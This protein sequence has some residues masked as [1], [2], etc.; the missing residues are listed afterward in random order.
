MRTNTQISLFDPTDPDE[1]HDV[2]V[3][4]KFTVER[5]PETRRICVEVERIVVCETREDIDVDERQDDVRDACE[6]A[7]ADAQ[8]EDP[9]DVRDRL[10]DARRDAA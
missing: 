9:D 3:E 1:F 7:W 6:Q 4:V 2:D 10:R 5:D 8:H